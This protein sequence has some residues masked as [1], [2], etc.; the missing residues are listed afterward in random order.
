MDTTA[1]I[2]APAAGTGRSGTLVSRLLISAAW[3]SGARVCAA[4]GDDPPPTGDDL[5]VE[6]L[7]AAVIAVR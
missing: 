2:R 1:L 4:F 3:H 5:A 6:L 7:A